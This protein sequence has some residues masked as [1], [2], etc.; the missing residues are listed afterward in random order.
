ME[1]FDELPEI[2]TEDADS[3]ADALLVVFEHGTVR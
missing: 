3:D 1:L 2:Q